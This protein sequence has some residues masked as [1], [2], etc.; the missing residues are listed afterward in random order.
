MASSNVAGIDLPRVSQDQFFVGTPLR[1]RDEVD[2]PVDIVFFADTDGP[3]IT[4]NGIAIGGDLFIHAR[5]ES[6]GTTIAARSTIRSSC[7]TTPGRG[8]RKARDAKALAPPG[9]TGGARASWCPQGFRL[10]H[11][12]GEATRHRREAVPS[13]AIQA[14]FAAAF[15]VTATSRNSIEA[16]FDVRA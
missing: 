14:S 6:R 9:N 10:L 7:C 2:P 13:A 15:G 11:P 16:A 5:D 12:L 8:D 4:H 3:G 1:G